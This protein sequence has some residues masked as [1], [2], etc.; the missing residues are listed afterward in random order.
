M[1]GI[2]GWNI[3]QGWTNL[4]I[5]KTAIITA[6]TLASG[7]EELDHAMVLIGFNTGKIGDIVYEPEDPNENPI[8]LD[9]NS[10]LIGQVYLVFKNSY[11]QNSSPYISFAWNPNNPVDIATPVKITGGISVNTSNPPQQ[12]FFDRDHDG[13]SGLHPGE[14]RPV[15]TISGISVR[16]DHSRR[17]CHL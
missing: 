9:V 12:Q 6:G 11:G 3:V 15:D 17:I 13:K 10:S 16:R 5:L 8:I 14:W 4:D 1:I 7:I 2:D